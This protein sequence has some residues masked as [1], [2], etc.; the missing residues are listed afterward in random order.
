MA[1]QGGLRSTVNLPL[2]AQRSQAQ[3][4][5]QREQARLLA[6]V[7]DFGD[8]DLVT[9]GLHENVY[10][11]RFQDARLQA[12]GRQRHVDLP[13]LLHA[14]LQAAGLPGC[15]HFCLGNHAYRP[16]LGSG[17]CIASTVAPG[18]LL[19]AAL[20]AL[21]PRSMQKDGATASNPISPPFMTCPSAV[22]AGAT[23]ARMFLA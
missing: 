13:A 3:V 9:A 23:P 14:C 17:P 1:G 12:R 19:T 4:V 8:A 11:A 21:G 18:S 6:A 2:Q 16:V 7:A 10:R 5:P 22:Q 20:P 15:T